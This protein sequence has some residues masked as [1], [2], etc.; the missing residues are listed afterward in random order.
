M[1]LESTIFKYFQSLVITDEPTIYDFL[2]ISLRPK[3]VIATFNWDPLLWQA[4]KRNKRWISMP[5]VAYL[6]GNVAIGFCNHD[7][8]LGERGS[9]CPKCLNDFDEVN[10][11]YPITKKN[12]KENPF[13]VAAWREIKK[14]LENAYILT[15]FGFGASKNDDGAV[16]ILEDAWG[17][18]AKRNLEQIEVI[19]IKDED[20]LKI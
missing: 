4:M 17:A 6:H 11:L 18:V 7:K 10:L 1:E 12:Y 16:S 15:I 19:D 8:Q 20:E 3:D 14:N 9:K 13:I 2:A 5:H